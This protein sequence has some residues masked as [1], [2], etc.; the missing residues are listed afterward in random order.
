MSAWRIKAAVP[1]VDINEVNNAR[2]VR[3]A[4]QRTLNFG[5]WKH[6]S[7]MAFWRCWL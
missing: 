6:H 7:D 4:E 3:D 2:L 1:P 5:H